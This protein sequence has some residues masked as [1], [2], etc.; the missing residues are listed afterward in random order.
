MAEQIDPSDWQQA[1]RLYLIRGRLLI[2][3]GHLR[4]TAQTRRQR[5]CK[6]S[7]DYPP[8]AREELVSVQVRGDGWVHAREVNE[9]YADRLLMQRCEYHD[10]PDAADAA[11]PD[12]QTYDP[13]RHPGHVL[14]FPRQAAA[15]ALAREACRM[16]ARDTEDAADWA[17]PAALPYDPALFALAMRVPG[18]PGVPAGSWQP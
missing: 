2:T 15:A 6:L 12:W 1:G 17:A 9:K 3:Y 11:L 4:C 14:G 13:G 18:L 16:Q 10:T 7:T 8:R 5:R